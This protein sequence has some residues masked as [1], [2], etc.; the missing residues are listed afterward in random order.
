MFKI[1]AGQ[2]SCK[3]AS[4]LVPRQWLSTLLVAPSGFYL[5]I[6]PLHYCALL[7]QCAEFFIL[8][9]SPVIKLSLSHPAQSG[10]ITAWGLENLAFTG[11]AARLSGCLHAAGS[12]FSQPLRH[13]PSLSYCLV[14]AVRAARL[15]GAAG[16]TPST[17][18]KQQNSE[19]AWDGSSIQGT[20]VENRT[21]VA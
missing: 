9:S 17:S 7:S 2:V 10:H 8:T 13:R 15:W 11:E 18:S 20:L 4:E 1:S 14:W 12:G 6:A 19:S 21:V 5:L 3:Q 16:I